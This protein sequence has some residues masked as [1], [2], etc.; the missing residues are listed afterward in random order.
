MTQEKVITKI[1]K[2]LALSKSPNEHE[3][4]LALA[5][6][7]ELLDRENLSLS[8]VE[9]VSTSDIETFLMD[10]KSR[11]PYWEQFLF[12]SL[13]KVSSCHPYSESRQRRIHLWVV[14]YKQDIEVFG[15]F[16]NFLKKTI[17]VLCDKAISN[18]RDAAKVWGRG[19]AF[20]YRNSFSVG[21]V[22]RVCERVNQI[23]QARL[24]QDVSCKALV[25]ARK[26]EVAV[27]VSSNLN[28][29]TRSKRA[30]MSQRGF[31]QGYQAGDRIPL[32][33]SISNSTF[34]RLSG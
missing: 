11:F 26:Q 19:E 14:G 24:S 22:T 7:Q 1:Q 29:Q 4:A 31:D 13:A 33:K 27:W 16:L 25:V 28:L 10:S 30:D 6:A 8:E 34:Q 12:T 3:A 21:V 5:K 32:H 17:S 2:L 15:Y 9:G 23:R 18:E 20:R